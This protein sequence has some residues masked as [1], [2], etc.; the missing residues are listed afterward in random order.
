MAKP[1][2]APPA[3]HGWLPVVWARSDHQKYLN[4]PYNYYR[5]G[6]AFYI[7]DRPRCL[8]LLLAS[9]WFPREDPR[10]G[11][12]LRAGL[13]RIPEMVGPALGITCPAC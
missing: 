6:G 2:S 9:G 1:V 3:L 7:T 11:R 10:S 8:P 4:P 13:T 12:I 5:V